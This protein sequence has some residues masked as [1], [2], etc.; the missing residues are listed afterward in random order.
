MNSAVAVSKLV[1][2]LLCKYNIE[3]FSKVVAVVWLC[4]GWGDLRAWNYIGKF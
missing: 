2:C 4:R 1:P 3:N